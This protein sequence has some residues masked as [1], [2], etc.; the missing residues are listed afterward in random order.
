MAGDK[1]I[2]SFQSA[3]PTL[4]FC[5]TCKYCK[6]SFSQQEVSYSGHIVSNETVAPD[7]AKIYDWPPPSNVKGL[8]G[9]LGLAGFYGKFIKNYAGITQT[10]TALVRKDSFHWDGETQ[11]ALDQLKH[12]MMTTPI[13]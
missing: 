1:S 3:P 12:A 11:Y 10:L 7:P 6:Y 9:F 8:R 5:E 2:S 13:L 4:I